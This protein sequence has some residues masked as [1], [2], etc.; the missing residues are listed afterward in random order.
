M[1]IVSRKDA[2]KR[3]MNSYFTGKECV[4]GHIAE[5]RVYDWKCRECERGRYREWRKKN[6]NYEKERYAKS[7]EVRDKKKKKAMD[8]YEKNKERVNKRKAEYE[9]ENIE[10]TRERSRRYLSEWRERP[11]SKAIMFMRRCIRRMIEYKKPASTECVIGYTRSDLIKHIES[12]FKEGM[13]WDNYG[14]WHIDHIRPINSFLESGEVD[15]S[16]INSLDNLQPLWASENVRKGD[17]YE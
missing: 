6:K 12:N 16:V 17:K 9:K 7:S 10:K 11:K 3:G 2:I 4:N 13:N 15:P 14:D 8:Y 1:E 5:R